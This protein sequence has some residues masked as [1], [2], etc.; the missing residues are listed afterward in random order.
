MNILDNIIGNTLGE[1]GV[2]QSEV[3]VYLAGRGITSTSAELLA[4]TDM[5]RPTVMAALKSL[6]DFGLCTTQRRDGRSLM[7][8]ML[9]VS[10]LKKYLGK[11]ARSLDDLMDRI[12]T[13][14]GEEQPAV[15][16]Q[17]TTDQKVLQDLLELALR[18]KSRQWHIIAPHDNALS[19]LPAA[20]LTYFKRI[21][22][23]RQIQ[24]ET[25]WEE[26]SSNQQVALADVLMRKPRYVPKELSKNI[27]SLLLAFDDK[28]LVVDGTSQPSAVLISSA[29]SAETVRILFKM[30]WRSAR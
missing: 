24:S 21:R 10:N 16:I 17:Q 26:S 14:D 18:C 2:N 9:P 15:S 19:H 5:P 29:S 23:E 30:A 22:K 27:P 8:T 6:Q 3:Q 20:Y 25:L 11:Q 13:L 12:D 28:L 1:A 4:R 7:Y